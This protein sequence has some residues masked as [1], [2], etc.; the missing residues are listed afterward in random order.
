MTQ[1]QANS[2]WLFPYKEV[3]EAELPSLE[4]VESVKA[5]KC[6]AV[7]LAPEEVQRACWC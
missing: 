4:D 3:R 2:A 7:V 5:S 6:L 1:D